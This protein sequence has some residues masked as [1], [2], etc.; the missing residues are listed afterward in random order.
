MKIKAAYYPRTMPYHIMLVALDGKHYITKT[1]PFRKILPGELIP[2]PGYDLTQPERFW[3]DYD[4]IP[5][6]A[7]RFYGLEIV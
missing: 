5:A 7:L 4:K 2:V 1:D 6:Y 3:N